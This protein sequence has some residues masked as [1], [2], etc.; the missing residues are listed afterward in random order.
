MIPY[1]RITS[2]LGDDTTRPVCA[3]VIAL[4]CS[5]PFPIAGNYIF[6]MCTARTAEIP[7]HMYLGLRVD[8]LVQA[9]IFGLPPLKTR[10][11]RSLACLFTGETVFDGRGP[12]GDEIY[13]QIYICAI[14]DFGG[15]GGGE[16]SNLSPDA[17]GNTQAALFG[18]LGFGG[19]CPCDE[20][21]P[22]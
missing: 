22:G 3:Y 13:G 11:E 14:H 12:W 6:K 7:G 4:S 10:R 17:F 15:G 21:G 1:G 19:K 2:T 20:G 9:H 16:P 18:M 5:L 8:G